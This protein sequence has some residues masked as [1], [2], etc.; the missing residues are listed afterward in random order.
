VGD[1]GV[2]A[3]PPL[4]CPVGRE[5]ATFIT[6][7]IKQE[8]RRVTAPLAYYTIGIATLWAFEKVVCAM[9]HVI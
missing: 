6:G 2:R 9:P 4:P 1:A 5:I 8:S 7:I 3:A